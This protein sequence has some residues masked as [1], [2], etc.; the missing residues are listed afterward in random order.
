[1]LPPALLSVPLS[2]SLPL[3]ALTSREPPSVL[4]RVPLMFLSTPER[5][6]SLPPESLR[7]EPL[8]TVTVPERTLVL[9]MFPS[10]T[11]PFPEMF[12]LRDRKL[13]C[14][15]VFTVSVVPAPEAA[16]LTA[17]PAFF[18]TMV[19]VSVTFPEACRMPPPKMMEPVP[20]APSP[21]MSTMP[22]SRDVEPP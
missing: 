9:A 17:S 20:S 4:A 14:P 8:A 10:A 15:A 6:I 3:A 11:A 1:M 5:A 2:A 21:L 19:C 22:P 12:Q 18:C 7:V 16:S 13:S